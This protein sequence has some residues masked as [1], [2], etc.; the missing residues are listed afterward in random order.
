MIGEKQ[1]HEHGV[2]RNRV[3]CPFRR[4]AWLVHLKIEAWPGFDRMAVHGA[5]EGHADPQQDAL[6]GQALQVPGAFQRLTRRRGEPHA[7][8]PLPLRLH[9]GERQGR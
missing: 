8:G 7:G 4:I 6:Q 2:S 5:E 9:H 3:E 1:A